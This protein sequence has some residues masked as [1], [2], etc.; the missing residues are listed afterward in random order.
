MSYHDLAQVYDLLMQDIDYNNWADYL[1]K[2]I[3]EHA[4]P[5][6]T[7]LDLGCGTG[8]ISLLL[9]QWGCIQNHQIFCT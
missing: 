7:V 6:T 4:A 2:Q 9:A 3:E 5:G 1:E 8:S